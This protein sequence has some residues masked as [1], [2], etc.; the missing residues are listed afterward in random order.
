M[1]V[2]ISMFVALVGLAGLAALFWLGGIE[3]SEG[4]KSERA[5]AVARAA[6]R[7]FKILGM[8]RP[9]QSFTYTPAGGGASQTMQVQMWLTQDQNGT[10]TYPIDNSAISPSPSTLA[11]YPLPVMPFSQTSLPTSGNGTP[12]PKCAAGPVQPGLLHRSDRHVCELRRCHAV[13]LLRSDWSLDRSLAAPD[14]GV[15]DRQRRWAP[16][17]MQYTYITGSSPPPASGSTPYCYPCLSRVNLRAY[18]TANLSSP[19]IAAYTAAQAE[20][21]FR[22]QDDL[23]LNAPEGDNPPTQ[24]FSGPTATPNRRQFQG[25]YSWLAT[26]V[27]SFRTFQT[28]YNAGAGTATITPQGDTNAVIVSIVVFYKRIPYL[29][30]NGPFNFAAAPHPNGW[31]PWRGPSTAR[32]F[33]RRQRIRPEPQGAIFNSPLAPR[34]RAWLTRRRSKPI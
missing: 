20:M 9:V 13:P 3:M 14:C 17:T 4:A 16:S 19:G 1:E 23:L 26:V 10:K 8:H 29:N 12:M 5:L 30:V 15:A 7:S 31:S 28:Y 6:Q 25:D 2:L 11:T 22:S 33:R 21:V 24:L 34:R 18:P 32:S 27:P